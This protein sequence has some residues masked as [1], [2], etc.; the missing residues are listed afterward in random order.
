M[1]V[2][3]LGSASEERSSRLPRTGAFLAVLTALLVVAGLLAHGFRVVESFEGWKYGL[4]PF[5]LLGGVNNAPVVAVLGSG[6]VL[7]LLRRPLGRWMVTAGALGALVVIVV[8]IVRLLV[9]I[10]HT[11]DGD[12]EGFL[13]MGLFFVCVGLLGPILTLVC[14]LARSTGEWLRRDRRGPSER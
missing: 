12:T 5:E 2:V 13:E 7:L 10:V 4:D 1:P 11:E 8:G 9:L 3:G 14:V 6:T